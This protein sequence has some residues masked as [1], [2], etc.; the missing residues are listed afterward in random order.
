MT[1]LA[2]RLPLRAR[3]WL[4]HWL[5]QAHPLLEFPDWSIDWNR[6]RWGVLSIAVLF[7]LFMFGLELCPWLK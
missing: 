4:R 6:D 2:A 1:A 5:P 7:F 3:R